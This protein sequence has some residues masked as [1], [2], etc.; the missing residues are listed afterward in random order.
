MQRI[1]QRAARSR[2]LRLELDHSAEA[3][4]RLIGVAHLHRRPGQAI[5]RLC[6]GRPQRKGEPVRGGRP[7]YLSGLAKGVAQVAVGFGIIAAQRDRSAI[8]RRRL[9]EAAAAY[10]RAIALRRDYP[11]AH[12]NL[13]NT[14]RKAGKIDRAAAAYRLALALRP[15]YAKAYDGL[16]GAA[17]EM[18]DADEAIACF[19]R[20]ECPIPDA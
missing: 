5:I 18:G 19:R 7:V 17:V 20:I 13:G 14:L 4:D 6:I 9:G 2:A 10:R 15:T 12:C 3:G 16:A 1:Q 11:E 8:R